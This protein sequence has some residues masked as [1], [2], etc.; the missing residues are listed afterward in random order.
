MVLS[1]IQTASLVVGIIYYITIMRNQQ[2]SQQQQLETRQAQM[3][4]GI[5]NRMGQ[6][7]F[8][9]AWKAFE[10][11]EFTDYDEY[12][13]LYADNQSGQFMRI[14]GTHFEGLGVFVRLGLVPIQYIAYFMTNMT[15]TYWEKL[16]P[17]VREY[18]KKDNVPRGLG[19]AEFLYDELMAY[20]EQ[21][22]EL[23]T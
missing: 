8:I 15:R 22:P 2:K 3:F 4:Y 13:K 21:H 20:L 16:A 10:S 12:M 19:E 9:E 7:D 18:R 5:Y 23:K 1:T 17:F 14:L 6:V 11:W